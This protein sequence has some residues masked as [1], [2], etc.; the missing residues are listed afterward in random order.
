MSPTRGYAKVMAAR[1]RLA[2]AE[3]RRK[4]AEE[5]YETEERYQIAQDKQDLEAAVDSMVDG[6]IERAMLGD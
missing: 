4:A 2:L 5:G 6:A 1:K 3:A